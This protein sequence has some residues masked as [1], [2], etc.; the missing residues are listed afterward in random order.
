MLLRNDF[1]VPDFCLPHS[2]LR[3][4][5]V[6]LF[7]LKYNFGCRYGSSPVYHFGTVSRD[8]PYEMRSPAAGCNMNDSDQD[9]YS[10]TE[11]HDHSPVTHSRPIPSPK[12]CPGTEATVTSHSP[13]G[14]YSQ[15]P[16]GASF[17]TPPRLSPLPPQERA[18][19]KYLQHAR[20][21]SA[22]L[23]HFR[24][25]S[26]DYPAQPIMNFKET[27]PD[28]TG[29]IDTDFTSR[30]AELNSWP[31]LR[32][33]SVE[34]VASCESMSS[35]SQPQ[36]PLTSHTSDSQSVAAMSTNSTENKAFD[37]SVFDKYYVEHQEMLKEQNAYLAR[38]QMVDQ[39]ATEIQE[40]DSTGWTRTRSWSHGDSPD[41]LGQDVALYERDF[42]ETLAPAVWCMTCLDSLIVAGC[43]N[44]RIEV[45]ALNAK[46][47]HWNNGS[48]VAPF[49]IPLMGSL[50]LKK[51]K[52][53]QADHLNV[54]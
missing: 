43:G 30:A 8:P 44:G 36:T 51:G 20:H 29:I 24:K 16:P 41:T 46:P 35:V 9:L 50:L 15:T 27:L 7:I 22:D 6:I 2:C 25:L 52:N 13:C 11:H 47:L 19:P 53:L 34:S 48:L 12:V 45:S 5:I 40:E 21:K 42:H 4:F 28:F 37:F 3:L 26:G 23:T 31:P 1:N 14:S 17:N 32:H 38:R 39:V 33:N 49:S 54:L 10:S 18:P